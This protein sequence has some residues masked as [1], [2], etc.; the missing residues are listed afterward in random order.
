MRRWQATRAEN[1]KRGDIVTLEGET[2]QVTLVTE[3]D[4]WVVV[5]RGD[6]GGVA[7]SPY[8]IVEVFRD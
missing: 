8:A 1:L 7:L 4:E 3:D 5:H 2:A 6:L